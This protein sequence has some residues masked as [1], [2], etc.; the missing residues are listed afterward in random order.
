[1]SDNVL[2]LTHV[3][4]SFGTR[5]LFHDVTF[6][7]DAGDKVGLIGDN[8]TGKSTLMRII[9]GLEPLDG[10]QRAL[11]SGVRVSYLEQVPT[12]RPGATAADILRE[13]FAELLN[14]MQAY[15]TAA[16]NMDPRADAL[17][18]SIERMGGWDW[19]HR[20]TRAALELGIDDLGRHVDTMSGGYQKRV[21]L[22]RLALSTPDLIL[23]DE[24]TNH[25]DAATVDWLEQWLT[26]T[27][28]TCLLVTHDRY[29]LER[30]V[31]RMAELREGVMRTYAGAYTHYLE[32][33]AQEEELQERHRHRRLQVLKTELAWARK[34]PPARSTKAKARL[35]RVVVAREEQERLRIKQETAEIAFHPAPRLGRTILELKDVSHGFGEDGPDLIANLDLLLR[36]GERYGI[37]GANGSGKTTLMRLITG[38]ITPRSG[39]I[40][41]GTNTQ[42]AYFDQHRTDLDL[43]KSL[44]DNLVPKGGDHVFP[45]GE[46]SQPVHVA[47]WLARF[48]FRTEAHNMV[49]GKLSGGERNRLALAKFLLQKANVLLLDEPTNDLDILTLNILEEA[50]LEFTGCIVVVSHDRYFLDKIATGIVAFEPDIGTPGQVTLIHGDFTTYCRLRLPEVETLREEYVAKKLKTQTQQH[51]RAKESSAQP[52][53]NASGDKTAKKKSN[54]TYG[55][56]KELSGMETLI[57][58][59]EQDIATLEAEL[60]NP[61][62][63]VTD[64]AAG[65]ALQNKITAARENV[66]SLYSRWEDLMTRAT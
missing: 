22:A 49:A 19:E 24:P 35:D 37:I 26:Q 40:V 23:L 52:S 61:D 32:A 55:E 38:D 5:V 31:T 14:T 66:N 45:G 10:G 34:S 57:A 59:A 51:A 21:A 2:S 20:V 64:P 4:K 18:D 7:V 25:L 29:F 3:S 60:A 36:P 54:L 27:S 48:A 15:E 46:N 1:M 11:R 62:L 9:A 50:L 41:R 58:R 43:E 33:R 47:S 6:G 13:P 42:I 39:T 16:Q 44:R 17:L 56:Q 28:A 65:I 12:L 63:W 8:G 30:V 53:T